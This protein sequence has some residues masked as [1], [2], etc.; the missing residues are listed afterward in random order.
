MAQR[1]TEGVVQ[2]RIV[3]GYAVFGRQKPDRQDMSVVAESRSII[4]LVG[5]DDSHDAEPSPRRQVED[6]DEVTFVDTVRLRSEHPSNSAARTARR[7]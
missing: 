6:E 1:P 5:P 7:R 4:E 3:E 2:A